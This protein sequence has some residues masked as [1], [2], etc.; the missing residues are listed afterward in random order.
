LIKNAKLDIIGQNLE[1]YLT[2]TWESNLVFK[3]SLQFLSGSLEQLAACL[4]KSGKENFVQLRAAFSNMTDE[5]GVNMLLRK[6]VY[7]YDYMNSVSRLQQDCL[8]AREHFFSRLTNKAC[9]EEDYAHAQ[10]VWNKF[11]CKTM[12]DYHDLYLKTDV[13]LLADVFESFRKATLDTFGLDPA[14]YVSA[15]QLSWDCMLKMTNCE[16]SLLSDPAMFKLI[17]NNLRG[18][19]SVITKRYAKANNK[20]M[21]E[22]FKSDEPSSYILYLDANNLYGWAMSEPLP[23]DDFA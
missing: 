23:Y 18:G 16:L 22:N 8:P 14:Y 15:P 12:Q 10:R 5:E 11:G 20:Y 4:L 1:K 7:P 17:N 13:L 9:S 6:G 21:G 2:L 19:I 3:D